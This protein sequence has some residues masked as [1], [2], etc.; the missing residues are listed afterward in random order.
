MPGPALR[1]SAF[2]ARQVRPSPSV[3]SRAREWRVLTPLARLRLRPAARP[4]SG[5]CRYRAVL[6]DLDG[7]LADTEP[8]VIACA[9]ETI[10]AAGHAVSEERLVRYIG[11]P[12]PVMLNRTCWAWTLDTAQQIYFDYLERYRTTYMPRTA[13]L[14]GAVELLD[15]LAA[16][17]IPLAVVTNK[18]EDAGRQSVRGAGLVGAVRDD[19]RG[20]HGGRAEAGRGADCVCA[21]GA[22]GRSRDEAALVGDTESDMGAGA[23]AGLAGVIGIVGGALGGVPARARRDGDCGGPW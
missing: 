13:P 5:G 21:G 4:L 14:P 19:H 17:E 23:A 12:M 15:R 6:F 3:M 22:G 11:P 16:L 1:V 10:R 20:R 2:V 9:L 7:T 8:L 18:R